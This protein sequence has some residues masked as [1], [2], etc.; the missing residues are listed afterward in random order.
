MSYAGPASQRG[1]KRTAANRPA[2]APEH[3]T[4]W[5]Q[6]AIFGVGLALGISLG[7][8]IALLTAPQPG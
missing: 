6:V 7:A 8:G 2:N 1:R 4:D 5:Q 3:D